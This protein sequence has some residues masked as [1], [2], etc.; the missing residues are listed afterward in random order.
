M[1]VYTNQTNSTPGTS[2]YSLP[3]I[4]GSNITLNS[5]NSG[6]VVNA[7][8][9]GGGSASDWSQYP[10]ISTITYSEGGGEANFTVLNATTSL[11]TPSVYATQVTTANLSTETIN[12]SAYPPASSG[13]IVGTLPIPA[14][15]TT[16]TSEI[17]GVT[18]SSVITG[19]Y[20]SSDASVII[21][22]LIPGTNEIT[23]NLS[24]AAPSGSRFNY[25][26]YPNAT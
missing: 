11:S 1:S 13:P 25:A 10:A 15:N 23:I 3:I 20:T 4:A 7:S 16:L 12:G 14:D 24:G 5:T 22:S 18:S 17:A 2:L 19:I 21:S 9:G 8:G 26:I 6:V